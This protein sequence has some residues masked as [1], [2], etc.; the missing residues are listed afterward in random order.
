M[1]L[2]LNEFVTA[3]VSSSL[4]LVGTVSLVSRFLHHRAESRLGSLRTVCR[5]CGTVFV[6]GHS[7]KLSHCTSCDSLNLHKGNGRLG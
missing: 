7:G 6:S 2:S 1:E 4:I 5:L 3:L